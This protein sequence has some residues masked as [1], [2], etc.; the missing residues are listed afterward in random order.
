MYGWP[1]R[2]MISAILDSLKKLSRNFG[3]ECIMN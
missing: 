1:S 2:V 3:D